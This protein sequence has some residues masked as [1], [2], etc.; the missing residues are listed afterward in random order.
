MYKPFRS[1]ISKRSALSRQYIPIKRSLCTEKP[2]STQKLIKEVMQDFWDGNQEES[3]KRMLQLRHENFGKSHYIHILNALSIMDYTEGDYLESIRYLDQ[4]EAF[5]D[6]YKLPTLKDVILLYR[7]DGLLNKSRLPTYKRRV[8]ENPLVF[9]KMQPNH[10]KS[11]LR[12]RSM[13]F[14]YLGDLEGLE[15]LIATLEQDYNSVIEVID[16][17]LA[18]YLLKRDFS[19]LETHILDF[20]DYKPFNSILLPLIIESAKRF[21][22][23]R[24][25]NDD[26]DD[27]DTHNTDAIEPSYLLH[28]NNLL[29]LYRRFATF[30]DAC[31]Y[32]H[33]L[34]PVHG[35]IKTALKEVSRHKN[36]LF[37]HLS[38]ALMPS[39]SEDV[40]FLTSITMLCDVINSDE[41]YMKHYGFTK[42]LTKLVTR[43]ERNWGLLEVIDDLLKIQEKFHSKRPELRVILLLKRFDIHYIGSNHDIQERI[44]SE[45]LEYYHHNKVNMKAKY[46]EELFPIILYHA[47]KTP[48]NDKKYDEALSL[49]NKYVDQDDMRNFKVISIKII[50][51]MMKANIYPYSFDNEIEYLLDTSNRHYDRKSLS[52]RSIPIYKKTCKSFLEFLVNIQTVSS[53]TT[54]EKTS[55][56]EYLHRCV[57]LINEV[58]LLC[59][60]GDAEIEYLSSHH[61]ALQMK[62]SL[63]YAELKDYGIAVDGLS[64]IAKVYSSFPTLRDVMASLTDSG[65]RALTMNQFEQK[66]VHITEESMNMIGPEANDIGKNVMR[67]ALVKKYMKEKNI[68]KAFESIMELS[69][70]VS[71]NLVVK[72]LRNILEDVALDEFTESEYQELLEMLKE[73]KEKG[74]QFIG[75]MY[76]CLRYTMELFESGRADPAILLAQ[77]KF[78]PTVLALL[79]VKKVPSEMAMVLG[80]FISGKIFDGSSTLIID[81]ISHIAKDEQDRVVVKLMLKRKLSQRLR[82]MAEQSYPF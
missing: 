26:F 24:S 4:C 45:L 41:F 75:A 57:E 38:H 23:D 33:R 7:L 51:S 59:D 29:T 35:A 61:I 71:S 44:L 31:V 47:L 42:F 70:T 46:R 16:M 5:A 15:D 76:V 37:T 20:P 9:E 3:K 60:L 1:L 56:K 80:T 78:E 10:K 32:D 18:F 74:N 79:S 12:S 73:E 49:C 30:F 52:I 13:E 19:S 72:M 64:A 58:V 67:L 81:N 39:A 40:S 53:N 27:D 25:S 50:I 2:K 43:G 11:W 36:S 66:L 22:V 34:A 28:I 63:V 65:Q 69:K 14:E 8:F 6:I 68:R 21:E 77:G 55:V 17:K 82:K 62:L 48:L 54:P